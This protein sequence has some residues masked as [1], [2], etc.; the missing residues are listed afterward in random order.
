M[1]APVTFSQ[2]TIDAGTSEGDFPAGYAVYVSSNG[3]T[4]GSP[5]ASGTGSTQLITVTFPAQ[6]AQYIQVVQTTTGVTTNWWSIA[7]F[8]VY[9]ATPPPGTPVALS[10]AS[11]TPSASASGGGAPANALDGNETT[12]WSTGAAQAAGQW[13]Q[14][15]MGAAQTFVEVTIYAGPSAGDYPHGYAVYVSSN[16]TSWGSPVASGTGST[17]LITVTFAQQTA[18]YIQVVQTTSGVTTNWWSI[19]EFNVW[20][21]YP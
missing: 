4:W 2:I 19:A 11:W 10:R 15:N 13:F 12:R 1:L 18:Q 9:S 7:E 17:Q 8:N 16:G 21:A 3:T 14:V 5:V 6:T 20:T